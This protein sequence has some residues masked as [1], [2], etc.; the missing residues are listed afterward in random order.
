MNA[1]QTHGNDKYC[2]VKAALRYIV[3]SFNEKKN[4]LKENKQNYKPKH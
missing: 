1:Y 2:M 3:K 4:L